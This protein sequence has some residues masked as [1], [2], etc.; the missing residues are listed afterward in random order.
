MFD[1]AVAR[2][3]KE[4]VPDVT[5]CRLSPYKPSSSDDQYL[6]TEDTKHYRAKIDNLRSSE[7]TK[8]HTKTNGWLA[9]SIHTTSHKP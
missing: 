4:L 5:V 8:A 1:G 9:R 6:A 2:R 3:R 7:L